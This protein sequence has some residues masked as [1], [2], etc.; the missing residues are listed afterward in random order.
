[1]NVLTLY[2]TIRHLRPRQIIA[3]ARFQFRRV[4]IGVI[5]EPTIAE[6]SGSWI[7]PAP[8][9][10]E[11]LGR[12]CFRLLG[13]DID[14]NEE[15]DW[16]PPGRDKLLL[17]HLHYMDV[18]NARDVTLDAR[19]GADLLECWIADNTAPNGNGWEP[20]PLSL[21]IVNW[22]KWHVKGNHLSKVV[23][24]SLFL[25]SR[26]LA[27]QIEYHLLA[28]HLLANAKALFFAGLFFDHPEAATW[29]E[30]GARI[31]RDE[32]QE[33]ILLDGGHFELSPMYQA[34]ITE[35]LLDIVNISRAFNDRSLRE[36]DALA[37]KMLDWLSL[38][39]HPDG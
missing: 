22:I 12:L 26:A 24:E 1:M 11:V 3:R 27:Q 30:I 23:T 4:R 16:N 15:G 10:G 25:Q 28:N 18:L 31:L 21:R 39:T 8:R 2:R 13:Q 5:T 20:Y 36:F 38:M 37:A 17:Y 35:D 9:R 19:Q 29:K 32:V 14:V 7:H 34:T 6:M 33:Q